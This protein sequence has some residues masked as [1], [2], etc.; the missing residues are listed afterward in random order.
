MDRL[1][2]LDKGRIVEEGPHAALLEK[3]G[4]YAKL[5]QRQSGGFMTQPDPT[6]AVIPA[7]PA[8]A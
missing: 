3:G 1:V 6:R 4:A 2:V 8:R 7:A 5:W